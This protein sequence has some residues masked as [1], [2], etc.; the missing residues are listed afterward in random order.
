[1]ESFVAVSDQQL[2]GNLSVLGHDEWYSLYCKTLDAL[3]KSGQ[4]K[5]AETL[6]NAVIVSKRFT[7][8]PGRTLV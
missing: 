5:E 6:S 2:S 1:M 8:V 7:R 3:V 4:L